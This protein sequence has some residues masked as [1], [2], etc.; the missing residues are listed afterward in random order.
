[1]N[2]QDNCDGRVFL[3]L[4]FFLS[5]HTYIVHANDDDDD[6]DN[7]QKYNSPEKKRK[8]ASDYHVKHFET[9]LTVCNNTP[10]AYNNEQELK[11][12][13]TNQNMAK[14]YKS[15]EIVGTHHHRNY[16]I[17]HLLLFY[18]YHFFFRCCAVCV[19]PSLECA[20]TQLYYL[21]FIFVRQLIFNLLTSF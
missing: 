13:Y 6:D 18:D 21:F 8:T 1:M 15:H 12:S 5:S 20:N 2:E 14:K 19:D 7:G 3:F 10:N 11:Y 9:Y 16:F 17:F 4:L